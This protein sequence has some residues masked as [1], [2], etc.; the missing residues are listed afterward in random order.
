M[1]RAGWCVAT[2]DAPGPY[3]ID[4]DDTGWE[5]P[6]GKPVGDHWRIVRGTPGAALRLE[7]E[8]PASEG[9]AVSDIRIGG[10]P[11]RWG[12]QLA[13]H[14]VVGAHTIAGSCRR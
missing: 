8:V 10:R 13:E 12:G 4:W 9:Y 14:I 7:Y 2:D 3:M 1:S 5:R 6:D 11:I